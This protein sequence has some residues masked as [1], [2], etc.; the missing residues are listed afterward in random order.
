MIITSPANERLKHARR[1]RE[2]REEG[3]IFIEGE[4]LAEE[5]L[6]SGLPLVAAFHLPEPGA[7][8]GAILAELERRAC[9]L[10]A[11]TEAVMSNLGDTVHPQGIVVLAASPRFTLDGILSPRGA[12]APLV[13]CLEAVQDPGNFGAILRTAEAA[14]ATGVIAT[15]GSVDLFAPKTLRGAM[16]SAFRLPAVEGVSA[17][18]LF[19]R[20]RAAGIAVAATAADGECVYTEYDWRRPV[21]IMFGNEARGVT[22]ELMERAD[23]RLRRP[24]RPPVESLNVAASA[25]AILFEA[26]RQREK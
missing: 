19:A 13:V 26:A 1:V 11:V 7:R 5:C 15:K 10:F 21:L 23:V 3:V 22:P 2:G 4:R 20:V 16:G 17:D 14:G 9:P 8:T 12:E 25:A 18:D 24:L 6:E